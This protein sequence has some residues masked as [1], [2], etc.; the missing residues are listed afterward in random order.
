MKKKSVIQ[1]QPKS[2]SLEHS[3]QGL[4][5]EAGE[6]F[7]TLDQYSKII[8]KLEENLVDLKANFPFRLLVKNEHD[9]SKRKLT[10]EHE[11]YAHGEFFTTK[12]LWY[13]AWESI[14]QNNKK[15][16]LFLISEEVETIHSGWE[17]TYEFFELSPKLLAKKPLIETDL[18]T[19]LHYFEHIDSFINAFKD[20]LHAYRV[21]IDRCNIPIIPNF[22]I[23][24]FEPLEF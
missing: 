18:Q 22:S 3:L 10:L 9:L 19:R 17:E 14:D 12:N 16:R 2:E 11:Q 6:L 7:K 4:F 5:S 8:L 13:L 24:P 1:P 15:F 23:T 21:L 20:H